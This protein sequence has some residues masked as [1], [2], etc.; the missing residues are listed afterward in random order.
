MHKILDTFILLKF[1]LILEIIFGFVN[2]L[3]RNS[4]DKYFY[5]WKFTIYFVYKFRFLEHRMR[6]T[7]K[8]KIFVKLEI[9]LMYFPS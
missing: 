2:S 1:G 3:L 6:K 9:F 5:I 8:I 7:L 4:K